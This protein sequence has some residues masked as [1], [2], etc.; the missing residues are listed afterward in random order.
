MP[1]LWSRN[2]FPKDLGS[3]FFEMQSP[4]K[5]IP[6]FQIFVGEE[7]PNLGGWEPKAHL[8]HKDLRKFI[9]L[10]DKTN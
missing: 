8:S 6:Y 9:F 5:I 7:E 10:L 3:I 2:A 4:W 1:A